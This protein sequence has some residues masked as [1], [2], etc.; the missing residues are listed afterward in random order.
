MD[1]DVEALL[2]RAA[3]SIEA[4]DQLLSAGHPAFAASRAYYAMFYTAQALL[5]SQGQ[6]YSSHRAVV[7]AFGKE[8]AKTERL[9][10]K[11]HRQLIDAFE[12]RQIA[13]Y[14]VRTEIPEHAAREAV[15]WARELLA[16]ADRFLRESG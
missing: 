16:A 2:A 13:D 15:G 9:D 8:F 11:H 4:A 12:R 5:L 6:T 10:P 1:P 14:A 7:A 3:E